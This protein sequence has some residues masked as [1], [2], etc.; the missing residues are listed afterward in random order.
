M[1]S[2]AYFNTIAFLL[3]TLFYALAMKPSLK[4]DTIE[5]K[6]I[7]KYLEYKSNKFM[8]LGAYFILV[9]LVQFSVNSSIITSNCGG[10][11]K[12][13]FGA[14]GMLT[15]IPWILIFGVII[16]VLIIFPGLKSAFSDVIGYYV[17]ANKANVIL[18]E[19]LIDSRVES[20]MGN[21]NEEDKKD[22]QLA[23]DAIIKIIGNNAVLINKIYPE[24]FINYWNTLL[25]LIKPEQRNNRDL[26]SSLFDL[27]VTRDSVG[28]IMW[29]VYT[30]VLLTFL[31]G[32]KIASRGCNSTPETM[33]ENLQRFKQE[34]AMDTK[35]ATQ[36]SN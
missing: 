4:L 17:V 10:S 21:A 29:Y 28:E 32:L 36:P 15:F 16:L 14:A 34:Q 9:V 27:V 18:T 22:I 20:K 24:N 33:A 30:G 11:V 19:L 26:K 35:A 6:D 31:V 25:P 13:N 7:N 5:D 2:S 12:E 8:Y 3:T 23:A 1:E